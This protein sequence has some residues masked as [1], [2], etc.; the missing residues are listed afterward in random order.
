MNGADLVFLCLPDQAAREAV[1]L[2]TNEM[3]IRDRPAA[4]PTMWEW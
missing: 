2:V 1:E 3:C 4:H